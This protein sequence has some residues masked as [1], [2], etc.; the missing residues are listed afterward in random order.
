MS[1]QDKRRWDEK[2]CRGDHA[3]QEPSSVITALDWELPRTGKALDVAGG[4]G[5]HAVWLAQRGLTVTLADISAEALSL[6]RQRVDALKVKLNTVQVDLEQQPFPAG[7]WDLILNVHFLW[8][9]LFD[10]FAS[11]LAPGG[12]LLFLQPTQ[13]NLQRHAKPSERY[14]LRDGELPLLARGLEIIRYDEGGLSDGRHEAVLIGRR[15]E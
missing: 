8:R 5:R 2:Y 12:L 6:A 11:S 13:S 7:P 14:L 4:A 1:D 9:P 3:G 15:T 10:V